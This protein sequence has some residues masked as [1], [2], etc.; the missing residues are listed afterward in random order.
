MKIT[1]EQIKELMEAA[2]QGEWSW[3]DQREPDE[4]GYIYTPQGSYLGDTMICLA[5]TYEDGQYDLSFIAALPQIAAFALERDAEVIRLREDAG[6]DGWKGQAQQ[7]INDN[8]RLHLEVKRLREHSEFLEW[9]I[10][11]VVAYMDE[12][13][14]S[15]A[16]VLEFA[17]GSK[18]VLEKCAKD[19][20]ALAGKEA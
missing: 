15:V 13:Q 7:A 9:Q 4:Y 17:C 20:G 6:E 5:D 10:A 14:P 1:S 11:N 16:P 19:R 12:H 18:E 8:A 3:S 2:T